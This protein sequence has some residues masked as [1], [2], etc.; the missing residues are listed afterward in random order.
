MSA[1]ARTRIAKKEH[2]RRLSAQARRSLS[3]QLR[4]TRLTGSRK[5]SPKS[6]AERNIS[7]TPA[8]RNS[9]YEDAE[10]PSDGSP[11]QTGQ[12]E[13]VIQSRGVSFSNIVEIYSYLENVR[14]AQHAI[15]TLRQM[16]PL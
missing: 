3:F 4:I 1:D 13:A 5:L 12:L 14:Q 10:I 2:G 16:F 15:V 11:Q 9:A 8:L 6:N 7:S